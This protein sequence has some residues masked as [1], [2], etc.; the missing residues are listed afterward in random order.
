MEIPARC[1]DGRLC[2]AVC[3]GFRSFW[4]FYSKESA[5][6]VVRKLTAR[7]AEVLKYIIDSIEKENRTPTIRQIGMKFKLRSTGS[8]RD[9]INALVKKGEVIKDPALSRG[10]RLNS[11][12][13]S[14]KVI[15]K[16]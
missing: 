9:I 13:Y 5:V 14:V 11:K 16:K 12:K 3:S 15:R 10:V 1:R 7:Q 4:D 2:R 6:A 8:V